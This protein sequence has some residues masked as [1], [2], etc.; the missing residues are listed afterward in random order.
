M[1]QNILTTDKFGCVKY[2]FIINICHLLMW[3]FEVSK[4]HL[5]ILIYIYICVPGIDN[6]LYNLY[7]II[8]IYKYILFSWT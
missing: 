6:I 5:N 3:S 4:R 2:T 8:F 7:I 1:I